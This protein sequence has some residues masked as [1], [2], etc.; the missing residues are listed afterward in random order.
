MRTGLSYDDVCLIPKC[1][2][3]ESRQDPA[4]H[5]K[6]S[7]NILMENPIVAANMDTVIGPELAQ[8]LVDNGSIP[9][10][11]RFVT[12][13]NMA[14][15]SEMIELFQDE[16]VVSIGVKGTEKTL[17]F[18]KEVGFKP[19]GVCVD[20]AH[21]HSKVVFDTIQTIKTYFPHTDV[22]AGNV[23]TGRAVHDLANAGADAV[24]VGIGPGS[25]CT[26]RN[27]T[28]F[29]RAQ[30]SA[31]LECAEVGQDLQVPIIADGGIKGSREVILALA[32]GASSVMIG[33]LFA[34]TYE[35][36]GKGTFRGQASEEFQQDYYG[37]VK[38]GTV[39]EGE[40][41]EVE[42]E[43]TAQELID[44]LLGG[45]RSGMT[46]GGAIDIFELQRKA[47]FEIVTPSYF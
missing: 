1:N 32:A 37:G 14:S 22:I 34:K 30:F 44:N 10:F 15:Y 26:T 47:E 2:N 23:C 21:G 31:V 17:N 7:K 19:M 24:K 8:V 33:G 40:S 4:T 3:I 42:L 25:A 5:T 36:A 16:G 13:Q 39:P 38:V 43:Y 29:G 28:A 6:L 41:K 27:V 20:I 9:I 18:W 12:Q 11:H 35:A 45:L 46:Y